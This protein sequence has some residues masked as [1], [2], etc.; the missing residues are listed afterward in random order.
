VLVKVVEA[1]EVYRARPTQITLAHSE[2]DSE[3]R[4]NPEDS[5]QDGSRWLTLD[6]FQLKGTSSFFLIIIKKKPFG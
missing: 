4:L 2:A 3:D 1:E 6:H 5:D